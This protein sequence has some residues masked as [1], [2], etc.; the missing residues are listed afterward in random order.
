[1]NSDQTTT[2]DKQ[3]S[4]LL[5]I[6]RVQLDRAIR[7]LLYIAENTDEVIQKLEVEMAKA[8]ADIDWEGSPHGQVKR[9]QDIDRVVNSIV[10]KWVGPH[11]LPMSDNQF[12][13]MRP[14]LTN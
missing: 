3:F 6:Q 13:R 14:T 10:H 4:H 12:K 9:G 5:R 2:T 11:F 7:E 8:N 1:M